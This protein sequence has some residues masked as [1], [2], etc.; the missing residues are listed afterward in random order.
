MS[1]Q[2]IGDRFR[3]L[4]YE[5]MIIRY[6]QPALTLT[7]LFWVLW[8]LVRKNI[9]EWPPPPTAPWLM[10]GG[11]VTL[12]FWLFTLIAPR[13]AYAQPFQDHLRLQTPIYRLKISYRRI[14]NTR[15][16][17]F[18]RTFPPST[19]RR[20]DRWLLKPFFGA[21]ALGVDVTDW[22]LSP[23][24]LKLFFNR[25]FLAPDQPSFVIL[26]RDWMGL[27]NQLSTLMN[28]WRGTSRERPRGPGIGVADILKED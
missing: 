9:L 18:G 11:L 23:G 17:D 15:P 27:S 12:I 16:I 8:Y 5:R 28:T 21:T 1:D 3:L 22:P 26:V 24:V 20:S 4:L 19:V 13:M 7:L 10:A 2:Q 6:R 25:Y 14:H